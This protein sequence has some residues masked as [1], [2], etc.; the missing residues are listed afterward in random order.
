MVLLF[1]PLA[2]IMLFSCVLLEVS[3]V[4]SLVRII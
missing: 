4:V 1:A 3:D 2:W